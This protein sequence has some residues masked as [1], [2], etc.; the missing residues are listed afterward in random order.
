MKRT[1]AWDRNARAG[2]GQARGLGR[3]VHIAV[4]EVDLVIAPLTG[5]ASVFFTTA[6]QTYLPIVAGSADLTEA[7]R[8]DAGEQVRNSLTYLVVV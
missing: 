7:K 6:C 5:V 2:H 4:P 8:E 3:V 1:C